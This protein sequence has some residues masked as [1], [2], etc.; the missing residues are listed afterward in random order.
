MATS[1][2]SWLRPIGNRPPNARTEQLNFVTRKA[3]GLVKRQHL[4]STRRRTCV[5]EGD[6]QHSFYR[7]PH[8]ETIHPPRGAK[9]RDGKRFFEIPKSWLDRAEVVRVIIGDTGS[10]YAIKPTLEY[11]R[12]S[13][14]P[15]GE[16]QNKSLSR[17]QTT[18]LRL[19]GTRIER[20]V[21]VAMSLAHGERR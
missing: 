8:D 9:R 1:R 17:K 4:K 2:S 21:I 6:L 11:G 16:H 7:L 19:H 3:F 15:G 14:P 12:A 13:K 10:P 18:N 20:W 5:D